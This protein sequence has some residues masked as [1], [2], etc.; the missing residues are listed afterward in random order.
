[1]AYVHTGGALLRFCGAN[2]VRSITSDTPR[3]AYVIFGLNSTTPAYK[4]E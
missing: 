3:K 1:M 2:Y 4:S